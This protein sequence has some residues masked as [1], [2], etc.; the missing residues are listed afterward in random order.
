MEKIPKVIPVVRLQP[1]AKLALQAFAC[2]QALD[3]MP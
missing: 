2:S 3:A 1:S